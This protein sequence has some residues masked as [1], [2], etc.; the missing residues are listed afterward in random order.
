MNRYIKISQDC[1]EYF[2]LLTF[3][4][5]FFSSSRNCQGNNLSLFL[6]L[7]IFK[8]LNLDFSEYMGFL[9][10][11]YNSLEYRNTNDSDSSKP[12]QPPAC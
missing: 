4:K 1:V 8:T 2:P 10:A 3:L 5:V 9:I 12:P 11:D 6:A 7:M